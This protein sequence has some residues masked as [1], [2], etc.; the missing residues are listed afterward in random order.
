MA[1]ILVIVPFALDADGVANR[2]KQQKYVQ[3]D[4]DTELTYRPVTAGPTSFMSP[5]DWTLMDLAIF[6]AGLSAEA[7]R[8]D[9]VCI[10]TMSD[11]GM[12]PLRSVLNIPVISPGKAS[13]LY[14]LT[15]GST[16]SILAQWEPALPRYRKAIRE[17]GF[18][19]QCASV[20]SFDQPPDFSSLLDGKEDKVFPRMLETA[21]RCIEDD[22]AEVICL[23][24]TTMH[25]AAEFL[26]RELPVPVINPGPLSYKLAETFLALNLRPGRAAYPAP[27]VPKTDIVHAMLA[28]GA[29]AEQDSSSMRAEDPKR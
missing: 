10:D 7:D 13:M 5:H 16:F 25:Q 17:Y 2:E 22:G 19:K 1:R 11:S 12:A 9:A 24:S 14:A 3:L 29:R 23:G 28:G 8:F 15:L 26:A 20:R 6:E 27:T 21:K 18:E 4:P